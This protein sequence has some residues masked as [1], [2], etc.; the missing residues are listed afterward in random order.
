MVAA[1]PKNCYL[2]QAL[3]ALV[4]L[5]TGERM[6]NAVKIVQ[7]MK[8]NPRDWKILDLKIVAGHFN[9]KWRQHGTSHVV[10]INAAGSVAPVPA[11]NPIL[12]VY[13]RNFL[14]LLDL[15]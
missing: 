12:P 8:N 7:R 11:A 1:R 15:E 10:F 6:S 14:K 9:V 4:I 5:G 2:R 13:V 3:W